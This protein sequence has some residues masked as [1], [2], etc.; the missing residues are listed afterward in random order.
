MEALG[1]PIA[2]NAALSGGWTADGYHPSVGAPTIAE[3]AFGSWSGAD[4]NQGEVAIGPFNA[5]DGAFA[6]ALVTG[7]ATAGLSIIVRDALTNETYL[8]F[9][10]HMRQEWRGLR[11]VLPPRAAGRPLM[12]IGRDAGAQYGQWLAI[13]QP[14]NAAR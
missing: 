12:L 4:A 14:H 11:I 5:A 1:P 6:I 10:P 8:A 13:S 2:A 9:Q 3:K 7:P